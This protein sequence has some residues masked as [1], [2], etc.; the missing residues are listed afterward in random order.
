M[1][2]FIR[3]LD[4]ATVW[5][6]CADVAEG[7]A[8]GPLWRARPER[9]R[10]ELWAQNWHCIYALGG[11]GPRAVQIQKVQAHATAAQRVAMGRRLFDG[12][13]VADKYAKLGAAVRACAEWCRRAYMDRYR[14]VLDMLEH[15]ARVS[16]LSR[17]VVDARL[18][19]PRRAC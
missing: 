4:G 5:A 12:S 3:A 16:C 11:I 2:R 9:K 8:C 1:G 18:A 13:N 14:I 10:A 17:D 15:A 19:S 7:V 6:D